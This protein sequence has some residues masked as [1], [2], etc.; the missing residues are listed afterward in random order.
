MADACH[1]FFPLRSPDWNVTAPHSHNRYPDGGWS[2]P[3]SSSVLRD[4][5]S[6]SLQRREGLVEDLRR[7][8][9]LGL[10]IRPT[11]VDAF[12]HPSDPNRGFKN[13]LTYK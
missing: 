1:S 2:R 11:Y 10:I 6:F 5:K 7:R 4:G 8:R 13:P 12:P 9:Q 3:V